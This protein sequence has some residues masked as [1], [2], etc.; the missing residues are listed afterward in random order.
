MNAII[1]IIV[2]SVDKNLINADYF[3]LSKVNKL[4]HEIHN[5]KRWLNKKLLHW[6]LIH[7]HIKLK[8]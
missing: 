4:S 8:I 6:K 1:V 3:P 5:F 2:C 7:G